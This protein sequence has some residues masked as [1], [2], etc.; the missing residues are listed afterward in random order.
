MAEE[1][2]TSVNEDQ[3]AVEKSVDN[4]AIEEKT[5]SSISDKI[6]LEKIIGEKSYEF[7]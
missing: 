6:D 1:K 3:S 4:S 5:T 2:E 7:Y